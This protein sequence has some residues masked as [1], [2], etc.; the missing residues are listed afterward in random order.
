MTSSLSD[1][2]LPTLHAEVRHFET[3]RQEAK[4]ARFRSV[5]T[6]GSRIMMAGVFLHA[7]DQIPI[8]ARLL[9]V[10]LLGQV[11][12]AS[13]IVMYATNPGFDLD[14]FLMRRPIARRFCWLGVLAFLLGMIKQP[15]RFASVNHGGPGTIGFVLTASIAIFGISSCPRLGR[16]PTQSTLLC[17]V[18]VA[19]QVALSWWSIM[20]GVGCRLFDVLHASTGPAILVSLGIVGCYRRLQATRLAGREGQGSQLDAVWLCASFNQVC[21]GA[22]NTL[23]GVLLWAEPGCIVNRKPTDVGWSYVLFRGICMLL[24]SVC[25]LLLGGHR[26]HRMFTDY[27]GSSFRQ[28]DKLAAFST[29]VGM[30]SMY[31]LSYRSWCMNAGQA[32]LQQ[33]TGTLG[34]LLTATG[35]G[36]MST[37]PPEEVDIDHAFG[38]RPDLQAGL[39]CTMC[40]Y[41]CIYGVSGGV[42][43]L[44][45]LPGLIAAQF[46]LCSR[47]FIR[48]RL[49]LR[50][51]PVYLLCAISVT[52]LAADAAWVFQLAIHCYSYNIAA[53][54]GFVFTTFVLACHI[55]RWWCIARGAVKGHVGSSPTLALYTCVYISHLLWGLHGI[56]EGGFR[57][58]GCSANAMSPDHRLVSPA[59]SVAKGIASIAPV[60]V[61]LGWGRR[62]LFNLMSRRFDRDPARAR[63]DGAFLATLL[64]SASRVC[65]GDTFWV[66]H[67]LDDSCFPMFDPQRNWE[68]GVIA[69]INPDTLIVK[70]PK[71]RSSVGHS[72]SFS[73]FRRA[74]RLSTSSILSAGTVEHEIPLAG[75]EMTVEDMLLLAQKELRCVDWKNISLELMTG[76][77]CGHD[78]PDIAHVYNL[79]RPVRKGEVIDYFMSH[80]WHDE[81]ESK[82]AR[83]N[84][85]VA[86]FERQHQRTPTFW[87]DKV[88]INQRRIADGLRVLPVNV[89]ACQQVLVLCGATYPERLWCIW[90]ICVV[91]SFAPPEQALERLRFEVL[92]DGSHTEILQRLQQFQVKRARCYDPNEQ[93]RLLQVIRAIGAD[94]F[95]AQ[96]RRFADAILQGA[97]G[98]LQPGKHYWKSMRS[99]D[100]L[101]AG[102]PKHSPRR[103]PSN[104]CVDTGDVVGAVSEDS[105]RSLRPVKSVAVPT[106]E[107][108]DDA[109]EEAEGA[110]RS[111]VLAI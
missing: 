4:I 34:V 59:G 103:L 20:H 108:A 63:R 31:L 77:I 93:A 52:K 95:D 101:G 65:I 71:A 51:R 36:I 35:L 30:T 3:Q 24:P 28:T 80:S 92:S 76:A 87:L 1:E 37:C 67:G 49:R 62:R 79:S 6:V 94:R 19:L 84:E 27:V 10:D 42:S 29:R 110:A 70:T 97:D 75:R 109:A 2:P 91:F 44:Y 21:N 61:L 106:G 17:A 57:F 100:V 22:M 54:F 102:S 55:L 58:F 48:D 64:D 41:F 82:W 68:R 39:G 89:M 73:Q 53:G 13:T 107:V 11:G 83:L 90:E 72:N 66:H 8:Q 105:M 25:W 12:L 18:C 38:E 98:T 99:A 33:V 40:A 74:A 60:L 16:C 32:T 78:A 104:I 88:C 5:V 50:P 47:Q 46:A 96:I 23:A 69:A 15:F 56:A 86:E 45:F 14:D 43:S 26:I 85:V 7:I 9:L 111:T 81:V